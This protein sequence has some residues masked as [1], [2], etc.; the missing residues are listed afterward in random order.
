MTR[1]IDGVVFVGSAVQSDDG[2][3]KQ[4]RVAANSQTPEGDYVVLSNGAKSWRRSDPM[5]PR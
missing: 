1:V 3:P 2:Q 5:Y 4:G